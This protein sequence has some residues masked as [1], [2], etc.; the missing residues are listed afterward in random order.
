MLSLDSPLTSYIAAAEARDTPAMVACLAPEVVLASPITDRFTFAGRDQLAVLLDDVY[1][2]LTDVRHVEDVGDARTRV[3]KLEA[4]VSG[5]PLQETM[6]VALDDAGLI[7]RMEV[8]V[9]PLP[10]L[11]AMA[12]AL[13]PRVARR[14]GR[15]RAIAVRALLAPLAFMTGRGDG[16]GARLAAPA[17]P[18][19]RR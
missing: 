7:T 13:A 11:T 15:L 18:R 19:G 9:R 8:Y 14:R 1:A 6:L 2:V 17:A 10:A 3:L 5:R 16:L 4:R 12:A